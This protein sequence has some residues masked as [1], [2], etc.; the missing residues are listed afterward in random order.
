MNHKSRILI[1]DSQE[2]WL[3]VL[4][5]AFSGEQFEVHAAR[6]YDEAQYALE[7]AS[8]HQPFSL[9]VVDPLLDEHRE[10]AQDGIQALGELMQGFPE[11]PIIVVTGSVG[12]AKM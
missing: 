12:Y 6:S 3:H 11:L 10:D 9:A 2:D 8:E 7:M 5:Q 1:V 4:R